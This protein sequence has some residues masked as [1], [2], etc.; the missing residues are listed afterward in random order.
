LSFEEFWDVRILQGEGAAIMM[1]TQ[2]ID[3]EEI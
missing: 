1:M 3:S 2:K